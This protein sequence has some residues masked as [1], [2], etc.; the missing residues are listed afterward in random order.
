MKALITALRAVHDEIRDRVIASMRDVSFE[1]LSRF[2]RDERADTI[3]RIDRVAEE[4]L[5]ELFERHLAG[6]LPVVLVAEGVEEGPIVLPRSARESDARFRIIV[7][8]IDGTRGLMFQK[9]S[10]WVLTGVAPNR[11]EETHLG[12]IEMA[13]QT[14]IPVIK[15]HIVDTLWGVR[16]EGT[17]GERLDLVRGTRSELRP[18]PSTAT[19]L[20]HGFATICRYCPGGRDVLAAVD[21]A[22]FSN[23][24][25]MD[26]PEPG[27]VFGFEDQYISTGGQLYELMMGHD[28][29][30]ADLRSLLAHLPGERAVHAST[31]HPYDICTELLAR[32]LGVV[33][34]DPTGQP[35][36]APL[37]LET[38]VSWTGYANAAL[39]DRILGPGRLVELLEEH[40]LLPG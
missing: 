32:E 11:G 21:E 24:D 12:D 28:R 35:L 1:E 20:E 15:Q 19:R 31:C 10:A 34:T 9:R 23:P 27:K 25:L 13:L 18:R 29:F 17:R 39:R 16:G 22:L 26:Q 40:G 30:V 4:H 38:P 37:D 36:R 5:V 2:D 14:E 33:V 6:F 7:D 8:P 3:Y